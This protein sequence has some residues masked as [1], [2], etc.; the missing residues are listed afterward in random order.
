[1]LPRVPST[2]LY[3]PEIWGGRGDLISGMT[4]EQRAVMCGPRIRHGRRVKPITADKDRTAR[5]DH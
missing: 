5:I 2:D 3:K 4:E 1:M